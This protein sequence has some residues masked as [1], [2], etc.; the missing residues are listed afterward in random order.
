MTELLGGRTALVTGG[1]GRLGRRIASVF[2]REG[3]AVAVA[4][5]DL[6]AARGAADAVAGRAAALAVD[7]SDEASVEHAVAA[8]EGELG[9][10]DCLVN[11]HG[12]VPN[13]ELLEM[14]VAEWDRVFA[15]N[16]RGT[17]LTTRCLA[18][19]WVSRGVPGS[20]VNLSSVAARSAR[21]GA[22]HYCS[23]KAAVEMLTQALALELGEHG[24]RVNAVAPGLVLD[25][26][27]EQP[28]PGLNSY[29]AAMLESTPLG[30][31]GSPDEIAEAA[32]YLASDRSRYTTGA[33]LEVTGGV[34]C[35]RTHMPL[36]GTM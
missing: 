11:C 28:A 9:A 4:D 35:G 26:V 33:V 8:A 1:G 25:D 3:A 32:A 27:V 29:V 34:H 15:V 13:Q 21:R 12:Y 24:I 19:R 30:R 36:S 6:A 23:S 31:T 14:D 18:R 22:S 2:A 5:L 7:V 20:V 10:L 16:V 17:M